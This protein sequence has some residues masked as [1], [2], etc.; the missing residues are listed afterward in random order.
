M[1][2]AYFLIGVQGSGKS[3]WARANAK[4]LRAAVLASDAIRNELEAKG[5]DATDEGDRVFAILE[6]RLARYLAQGRN[7]IVDA[8]HARRLWRKQSL[9][10]ARV[11]G[12]WTVAVWLDVPLEVCLERNQRKPGS[13]LWGERVVPENVLRGVAQGFEPPSR[14]EFDEVWRVESRQGNT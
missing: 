14:G 9:F 12:A 10:I 7:V 5:I 2:T 3:T 13:K 6:T 1:P 11:Q 4:R 8:T